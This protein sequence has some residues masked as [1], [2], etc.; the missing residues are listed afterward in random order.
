MPLLSAI[1][2]ETTIPPEAKEMAALLGQQI[3][4]LEPGSRTSMPN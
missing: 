2:Q 1:E 3:E 4:Q